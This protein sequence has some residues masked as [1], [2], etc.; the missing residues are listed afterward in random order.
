M[1][2]GS[3]KVDCITIP[4]FTFTSLAPDSAFALAM[5]RA[6]LFR[7]PLLLGGSLWLLCSKGLAQIGHPFDIADFG[8]LRSRLSFPGTLCIPKAGN[9]IG[10]AAHSNAGDN[11][12]G[13]DLL[14]DL[15]SPGGW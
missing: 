13:H 9:L 12:T 6:F 4:A 15:R 3:D 8:R 14:D 1:R 11:T 7:V 10:G 5:L 2:G